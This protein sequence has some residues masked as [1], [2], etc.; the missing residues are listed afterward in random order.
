MLNDDRISVLDD[1]SGESMAERL[2]DSSLSTLKDEQTRLIFLAL[3]VT[4]EDVAVPLPAA[5]LICGADAEVAGKGKVNAIL[6]RRS[7]KTL[8]DRNLLQGTIA[9]GVWMHGVCGSSAEKLLRTNNP[10]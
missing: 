6:M 10:V 2:V 5:Q 3:G 8:L 4:P 7:V 1:G 9:H